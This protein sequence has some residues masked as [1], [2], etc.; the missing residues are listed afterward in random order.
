[1]VNSHSAYI[2]M[3]S[4]LQDPVTQILEAF[5]ALHDIKETACLA[6]SGFYQS[7]AVG[8]GQ[9]PDYIN[10]VALLHTCLAPL[11]LLDALQAIEAR[12][13][14]QRQERWGPRTLDLD[15]LLYGDMVINEPRLC[16]PH[17]HMHLRNFVLAPLSDLAP[18]LVLPNGSALN[19]LIARNGMDG[20][21]RF[22]P[23]TE[24]R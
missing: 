17:P 24:S 3:G 5:A 1:M 7:A 4:N 11:D 8:P 16:V 18:G 6:L 19:E 10:A 14:R 15:V 13:L 23:S 21:R 2:G 20:L 9:Q 12:H 22:S